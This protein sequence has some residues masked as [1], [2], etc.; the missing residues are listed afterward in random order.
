MQ[1]TYCWAGPVLAREL[2]YRRRLTTLPPEGEREVNGRGR[3]G[4]DR[5]RPGAHAFLWR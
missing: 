2:G 3:P 5:V 4:A 1:V